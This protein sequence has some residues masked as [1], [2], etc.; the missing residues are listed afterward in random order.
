[1]RC[2]TLS[3]CCSL[4][5]A[6]ACGARTGLEVLAQSTPPGDASAEASAPCTKAPWVLFDY[7]VQGMGYEIFAIHPDGSSLHALDLGTTRTANPSISPDGASLLYRTYSDTDDTLLLRDLASGTTR[8]IVHIT[9]QPPSSGLSKGAVSPDNRLI[10]YGN[11][12]DVHLVAFDGSNDRVLVSGPYEAGC[13]PW[14]YGHPAFG[15][16][17]ST[18]YFSTIGRLEEIRVDGSGRR[19]LEQDQFFSNPQDPGF[20]FP[21][22]SFSPEYDALVAQ[23]ACDVSEL[24]VYPLGS[25]P[26][27]PCAAGTKLAI[28]Q[29]SQGAS[30]EAAN[31]SW[32]P[33]GLIVYDDGVDLFLVPATGGTPQNITAS[34]TTGG[35]MAADPVWASGCSTL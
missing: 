8:T 25:L 29:G 5:F 6:C 12:P 13:C 24:R 31:P 1:M 21:N 22:A 18:V 14:S 28:L 23:V 11:S 3:L 2:P 4:A 10:A 34:I 26:G 7:D 20:S 30:N 27:D 15:A 32:G 9:V 35:R 17:S 16:D 33:T 19:L